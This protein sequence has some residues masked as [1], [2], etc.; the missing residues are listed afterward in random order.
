MKITLLYLNL[1]Q[2]GVQRMMVNVANYLHANGYDVTVVLCRQ[3]GHYQDILNAGIRIVS[4]ESDSR[5][6]LI[7]FLTT[8]LKKEK[9]DVLFTAVPHLNNIALLSR[10]LARVDTRIIISER[11]NTVEEFNK[12]PLSAYKL[13]FGLIPILYRF[14][15]AII[16]VSKGVAD[17]LS[18]VALIPRSTISVI[19]NPAFSPKL[20][21]EAIEPVNDRW[22]ANKEYPVIVGVGRLTEQKDFGLLIDAVYQLNQLRPVRLLIIGEGPLRDELQR[23]IDGY[24]LANFVRMVGFQGKP[25]AWINKADAFVL[26]SKWEGFGNILVE[27][28]AAGTTIVSTDCKS[29]PA[30]I[31]ADGKYGY[32]VPVSN[33][34]ALADAIKYALDNPLPKTMLQER[35]KEYDV[36][37]V[38]KKYEKIITGFSIKRQKQKSY[39][40]NVY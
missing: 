32:L 27:A 5:L 1:N 36:S 40:E 10:A 38:M 34:P 24:K 6:S 35:A 13:S 11:S 8:Y 22:L 12:S 14:A 37:I 3:E 18:K 30:E 26:S 4:L 29:G 23:K 25:T 21:T 33:V 7:R 15:D 16:A 31:L 2:G 39:G 17:D 9:P 19:Y 20:L 28:L